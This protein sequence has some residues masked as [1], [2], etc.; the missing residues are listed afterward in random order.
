LGT[1]EITRE[2]IRVLFFYFS[3]VA[4]LIANEIISLGGN[5]IPSLVLAIEIIQQTLL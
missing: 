4:F 3:V 5:V 2:G 1:S